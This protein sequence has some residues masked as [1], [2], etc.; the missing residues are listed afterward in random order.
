MTFLL[1]GV[2]LAA[3]LAELQ[4]DVLGRAEPAMPL[5]IAA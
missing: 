2:G 3:Q 4:H 5:V 1:P